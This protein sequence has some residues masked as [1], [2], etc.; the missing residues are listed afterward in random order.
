M[1]ATLRTPR[2]AAVLAL[3]AALAVALPAFAQG[4][5]ARDAARLPEAATATREMV[6]TA[7]PLASEA[8]ALM[9]R[10]GGTAADA[11]VAAQ[12][13][14]GLVEPQSSGIGGGA[15]ALWR[16]GANGALVT[17]DA[18]ETAPMAATPERFLDA[19]AAPLE[20]ADAWQSGLSVGVPG[21]PALM[22]ATHDR[23]GRLPRATVFAPARR[24]ALAG[25]PLSGR[26]A[27]QVEGLLKRN[28]S[29]ADRLF[30]RDPAAFA[31]FVEGDATACAAKPAGT[32]LRNPAYARLMRRL[33]RRG[34]AGFYAGP[35][36]R[37]VVEAVRSDP[38]RPGDMTLDDL[39]A[40]RVIARAPV[41][42]GYRG[43][44]VC[45]MGPP[46][47][48]GV[49]VGQMLR[50]L[51]GFDLGDDPLGERALHLFAE[52]GRLAFADRNRYVADA[53]FVPVPV[54]GLLDPGYL[55]ARAALIGERDMGAAAPGDPPGAA[56][57]GAHVRAKDSGTSH[58]SIIDR[59][60]NAL[61]MTTTVE[62]SFG[63]GVMVPGF[64][65]LLNNELTDFSFAPVDESGDPVANRVEPGKRPR[66]SMSPTIVFDAEGALSVVTGSPGGSRI[67]GYTARALVNALDF[68]LDAQAAVSAPHVQNRNGA[69]EVEATGETVWP[70][71]DP[72]ALAAALKARGHETR[73]APM[74]SGLSMIVVGPDGRLTG[75]ADPRRDGVA[76]GR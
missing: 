46:S 3:L 21:V 27:D 39:A 38:N 36:A 4:V 75:G 7:H 50:M 12:T 32:I 10:L 33:A 18:R 63:N 1:Q 26:T 40:Y 66:S 65:F 8:G 70:G 47:S 20:F 69:T 30:F 44:T 15:F 76:A 72:E 16:D 51:E 13:V 74:T 48:G 17:L 49:A 14:L 35:V 37:A 43:R 67:I 57:A 41:C 68:G 5:A 45:G 42:V 22:Q 34:A 59:F 58:V 11:M 53:D 61:S 52:A 54:A 55:A 31:H 25:F 64:G 73:V 2:R 56:A 62:S 60:G 28:A 29:C 6:V 23:W 19:V 9:L 24:L 71:Y